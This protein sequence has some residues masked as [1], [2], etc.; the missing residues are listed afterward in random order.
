MSELI[1]CPNCHS[2]RVGH[3][4]FDSDWGYGGDWRPANH[5]DSFEVDPAAG[6]TEEDAL[7]FSNNERPDIDCYICCI[8]NTHFEG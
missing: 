1:E 5:L 3:M 4:R 8:C 7:E 6:Y 2:P